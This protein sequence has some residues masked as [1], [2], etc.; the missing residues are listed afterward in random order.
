MA[1]ADR[2]VLEALFRATG[3]DGWRNKANWA[4]SADLSTWHGVKL[5][6]DGRVLEL[7]LLNKN[8][9]GIVGRVL[10]THAAYSR[11]A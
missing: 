7:D 6:E 11:C 1:S 8:L 9:Q 4:T 3:G 2:D 10:R 5:D